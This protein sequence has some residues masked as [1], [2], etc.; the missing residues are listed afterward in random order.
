[1]GAGNFDRI[2]VYL[3][4]QEKRERTSRTTDSRRI[5]SSKESRRSLDATLDLEESRELRVVESFALN[6]RKTRDDSR[7]NIVRDDDARAS[8]SK[9]SSYAIALEALSRSLVARSSSL[10]RVR[11]SRERYVVSYRALLRARVSRSFDIVEAFVVVVSFISFERTRTLARSIV[12][13]ERFV[14]V[15]LARVVRRY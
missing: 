5:E 7:V 12:S 2:S 8:L 6:A 13:K 3:G 14:S 4:T 1:M 11:E 15:S 10:S 9:R